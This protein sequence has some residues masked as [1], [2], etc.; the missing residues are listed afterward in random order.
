MQLDKENKP[1]SDFE[2]NSKLEKTSNLFSKDVIISLLII[3]CISLL[4]RFYFWTPNI[5]LTLDALQ[6]FWYAND[7]NILGHLPTT[8]IENNGW[9]AF[10]SIFFLVFHFNNF[11]DYMV[12]QRVITISISVLTIVPVYLLCTRFFKKSYSLV[13]A[14]LFVF[15][16]RITQNSLL[17][18][19]DPLYI[20]LVTIVMFL[21]LSTNKK[22]IYLSF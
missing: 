3:G 4:V 17:G 21:F 13:G 7:L 14:A 2:I 18:I 6:Y 15:E 16:P 9:P 11:M 1:D 8:I 5:P 12:L 20:L 10:L 22:L 19:T